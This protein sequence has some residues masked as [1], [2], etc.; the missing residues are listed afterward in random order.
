MD[1]IIEWLKTLQLHPV[2]D[3]FTI[4]LLATGVVLDLVGS[5]ASTRTW[6][7][8]SAL[9]LI[10]L[11][12]IATAA[13]FYTGHWDA[14]A[15]EDLLSGAPK[16]ALE[17]HEEFGHWILYAFIAIAVWRLA[18]Q[19]FDFI[20]RT[21]NIY[22]VVAVVAVVALFWQGHWGGELVYE[23]GIGTELLKPSAAPSA[24]MTP[25][26]PTS[27][28]WTPTPTSTASAQATPIPGASPTHPGDASSTAGAS[29]LPS[30]STSSESAP[31][32]GATPSASP[33]TTPQ[34]E[35][36]V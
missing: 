26:G 6:L 18:I 27:P 33:T 16:D 5:F 4:A 10:V 28:E 34:P 19:A 1:A 7:R 25:S 11:G 35:P 13:S 21:R 9:T 29:P 30:P 24:E 15:V 2:A 32:A 23:Y 3:H 12:T 17:W 36:G 22:L 20:A 31:P 8:Y 14:E